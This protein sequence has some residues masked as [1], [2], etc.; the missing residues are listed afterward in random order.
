MNSL[1]SFTM[2]VCDTKI[3]YHRNG[4]LGQGFHI[5]LFG[6]RDP[7]AK[8]MRAMMAT[9]F[10]APGACAVLDVAET[11]AGNIAFAQ[12]NSWRGDDFEPALREA[13]AAWER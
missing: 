6:W 1:G 12:G 3:S 11:A 9:V 13:I 5:V 10:D 4:V 2:T 8:R 7:E